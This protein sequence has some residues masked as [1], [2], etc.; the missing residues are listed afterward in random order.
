MHPQA[1]QTQKQRRRGRFGDDHHLV[2]VEAVIV[3]KTAEGGR[4]TGIQPGHLGEVE[5]RGVDVAEQGVPGVEAKVIG[6]ADV[7][8]G[9]RSGDAQPVALDPIR[10]SAGGNQPVNPVA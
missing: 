2:I 5:R 9:A 3:L 10:S 6:L 8:G 7:E 4:L 1:P